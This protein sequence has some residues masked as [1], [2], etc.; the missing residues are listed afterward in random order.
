MATKMAPAYANIFMG[1]LE[2]KLLEGYHTTPI[3]WKRYIDDVFCVW[4]DPAQD[5]KRFIEYLD[6]IRA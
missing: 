2:D 1:D 4:R 6:N 5:L 3:V